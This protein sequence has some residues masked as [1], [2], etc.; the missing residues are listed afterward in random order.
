MFPWSNI[1]LEAVIRHFQCF[2]QVKREQRTQCVMLKSVLKLA[3]I[4]SDI[5]I[6][7]QMLHMN[8]L[9]PFA[10]LPLTVVHFF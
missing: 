6:S 2:C 4:L 3:V 7:S 8:L 1:L 5:W 10:A 9:T